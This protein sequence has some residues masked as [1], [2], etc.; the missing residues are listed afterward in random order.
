M[1]KPAASRAKLEQIH[2]VSA[3][4]VVMEQFV[5]VNE[6]VY[7]KAAQALRAIVALE[8]KEPVAN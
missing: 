8:P 1:A 3:L 6:K 4:S 5:G 7:S 2:A